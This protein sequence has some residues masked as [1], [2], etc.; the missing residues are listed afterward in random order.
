MPL[1]HKNTNSLIAKYCGS[2]ALM[3]ARSLY[4]QG[5]RSDTDENG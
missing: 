5:K 3:F 2:L 1:S 4:C